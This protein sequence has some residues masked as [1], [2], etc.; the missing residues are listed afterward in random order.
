LGDRF[1]E[2]A[3]VVLDQPERARLAD[4]LVEGGRSGQI[5]EDERQTLD[6]EL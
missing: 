1:A 6:R 3:E 4:V 2:Q 5:G